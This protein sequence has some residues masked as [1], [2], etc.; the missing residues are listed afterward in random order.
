MSPNDTR[1][2]RRIDVEQCDSGNP[3]LRRSAATGEVDESLVEL[4]T[5]ILGTDTHARIY[6]YLRQQPGATSE[7]IATGTGLYPST[8]RESLAVLH[9]E[10]TVE[11]S[12]CTLNADDYRYVYESIPPT[13]LVLD[14]L[15][16][17]QEKLNT[18]FVL[19]ELLGVKNSSDRQS[20]SHVSPRGA[21]DTQHHEED[22]DQAHARQQAPISVSVTETKS[23]SDGE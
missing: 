9:E 1:D 7:E 10:G 14:I 15:E 18:V 16:P 22:P 6:L 19:D 4:L 5:W 12:E 21:G 2:E 3:Q 20:G 13:E 11:R 17:I 8:V 23:G